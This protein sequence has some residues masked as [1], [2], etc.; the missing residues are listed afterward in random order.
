VAAAWA[1]AIGLASGACTVRVDTEERTA[2]E[3][4]LFKVTGQPDVRIATFDGSVEIRSWDRDEVLVEVEKRGADEEALRSIQVR[5]EQQGNRIDVDVTRP[6]GRDTFAGIGIHIS[7]AARLLV[8]VPRRVTLTARSGDGSIRVDRLEGRIELRTSDGSVRA[9]EV[10]GSLDIDTHDG[11]ITVE[12]ADGD[13]TLS[14]RDG[15][16]TVAGRLG[17]VKAKTGDGSITIRAERGTSMSDDWSVI[18]EDGTVALY[19]PEEFAAEVDAQTDDGRVRSDFTLETE[20]EES[21]RR[22]ARGKLNAG[23]HELRVRTGDG[24]IAL[25]TW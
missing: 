2:R 3:E 20:R 1:L 21:H 13:V 16:I 9:D 19:L 17:R 15:G 4:K 10:K 11:S 24:S 25:R 8:T 22:W 6:S 23:G 18:T 14:T 12:D 5:A 7:T